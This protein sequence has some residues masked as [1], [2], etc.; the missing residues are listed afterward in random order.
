[1]PQN[2]DSESVL[3]TAAFLTYGINITKFTETSLY[4]ITLGVKMVRQCQRKTEIG[5]LSEGVFQVVED[6]ISTC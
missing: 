3:V 4:S 2:V 1:V 5:T 6:G